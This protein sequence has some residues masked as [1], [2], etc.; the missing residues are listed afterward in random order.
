MSTSLTFS[1]CTRWDQVFFSIT[2]RITAVSIV[3]RWS[4]RVRTFQEKHM[5]VKNQ[6]SLGDN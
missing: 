2:K 5:R 6:N 1:V 4:L 3:L